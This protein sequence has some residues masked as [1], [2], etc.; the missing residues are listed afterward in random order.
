MKRLLATCLAVLS[1]TLAAEGFIRAITEPETLFEFSFSLGAQSPSEKYG[2]LFTPNWSGYMRH[3]DKVWGVPI[4]FEEHGY[5]TPGHSDLPGEPTRVVLL[6]GR[7]T[8]MSYGLPDHKTIQHRMAQRAARPMEVWSTGWAGFDDYRA[9]KYFEE[10]LG[11][12]LDFDVVLLCINPHHGD[13]FLKAIPEDLGEVRRHPVQDVMFVLIDGIVRVPTDGLERWMGRNY[14]RSYVAYGF[15]RYRKD[16]RRLW[17]DA[18]ARLGLAEPAA[19]PARDAAEQAELERQGLE[20]LGRFIELLD[21]HF[22]S[23]GGR[24][25][26]VLMPSMKEPADT[27]AAIAAAIPADVPQLD[28]HRELFGRY[29]PRV[30]IGLGHYGEDQARVIGGRMLDF[31]EGILAEGG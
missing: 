13:L 29:P 12:E 14:F 6:G 17:A 21:A 15:L 7:S 10:G 8:A 11:R 27:Y 3:P 4:R 25:G 24:L 2:F 30:W 31:V 28:L 20:R 23:R 18:T 9:W 1:G 22:A 5:R 16:A 19:P 26:V